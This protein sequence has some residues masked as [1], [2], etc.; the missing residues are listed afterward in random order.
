MRVK[1]NIAICDDDQNQLTETA[2]LC[3][4]A[5]D[6][7]K[8][9]FPFVIQPYGTGEELIAAFEKNSPPE[10]DIVLMDIEFGQAHINGIEATKILRGMGVSVPVI[11]TSA[12]ESYLRQGYGLGIMRYDDHGEIPVFSQL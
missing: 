4:Q 1:M 5:A 10:V 9:P 6:D 11:I 7:L 2:T 8:C 3:K 12:Y